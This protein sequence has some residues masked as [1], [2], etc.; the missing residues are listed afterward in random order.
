[1]SFVGKENELELHKKDNKE[2]NLNT[3]GVE[4]GRSTIEFF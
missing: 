3:V 4:N 1:M 2:Q